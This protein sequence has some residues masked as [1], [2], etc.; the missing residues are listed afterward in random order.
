MV[1]GVRYKVSLSAPHS[2]HPTRGSHIPSALEI[3]VRAPLR[4]AKSHVPSTLMLTPTR[5]LAPRHP[6][7]VAVL[8]AEREADGSLQIARCSLRPASHPS[9]SSSRGGV[10]PT[11]S[12]EKERPTEE[13]PFL[14]ATEA[15]DCDSVALAEESRP[16]SY[17]T[18]P[19]Y[20]A[21]STA[22]TRTLPCS[23]PPCSE[24]YRGR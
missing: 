15:A 3:R 1:T 23:T 13:R 18:V 7:G 4:Y 6:R 19:R 10:V 8:A 17:P 22:P 5:R 20:A 9:S 11:L 21:S 16:P 12:R 14:A 24:S 2:R